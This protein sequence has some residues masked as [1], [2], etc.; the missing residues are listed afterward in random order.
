MEIYFFPYS[1]RT[2]RIF[3]KYRLMYS[4]HFWFINSGPVKTLMNTPV[5][6]INFLS[7][8][9]F[10]KIPDFRQHNIVYKILFKEDNKIYQVF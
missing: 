6:Q 2:W 10:F 7:D 9:P 1:L 3:S 8:Y 5:K 4:K